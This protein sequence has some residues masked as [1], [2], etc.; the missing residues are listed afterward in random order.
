MRIW[1]GIYSLSSL[2]TTL[3]P[4]IPCGLT[5]TKQLRQRWLKN[6]GSVAN[7]KVTSFRD[8]I[9]NNYELS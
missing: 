3:A 4:D 2:I 6:T 1:S 7:D 5:E 9:H 8:Y